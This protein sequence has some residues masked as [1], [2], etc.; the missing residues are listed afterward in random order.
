MVAAN[1]IAVIGIPHNKT[2]PTFFHFFSLPSSKHIMV[3]GK[4]ITRIVILKAPIRANQSV[5]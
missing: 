3:L 4:A 2:N 1:P 5:T